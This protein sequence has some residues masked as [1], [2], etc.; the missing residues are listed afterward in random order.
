MK[1]MTHDRIRKLVNRFSDYEIEHMCVRLKTLIKKHIPLRV[2]KA[3]SKK[4][5]NHMGQKISLFI[6]VVYH[7]TFHVKA[8]LFTGKT[9]LHFY[10]YL[11]I[12]S[13]LSQLNPLCSQLYFNTF[14][15]V[16]DSIFSSCTQVPKNSS[17]CFE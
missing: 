3:A 7:W 6:R 12:T 17:I 1:A 4:S 11:I 10:S 5:S 2:L 14:A 15:R 16:I 13:F 8:G 9:R